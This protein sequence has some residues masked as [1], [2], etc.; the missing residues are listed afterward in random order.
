MRCMRTRAVGPDPS[1]WLMRP[2]VTLV[3]KTRYPPIV[4]GAVCI[5]TQWLRR[6]GNVP[7]DDARRRVAHPLTPRPLSKR[8][9]AASSYPQARAAI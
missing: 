5:G 9:V 8:L 3:K 2:A 4:Y 7:L 1:S 6:A